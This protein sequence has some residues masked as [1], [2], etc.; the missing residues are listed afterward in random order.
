MWQ[1]V[2]VLEHL[3]AIHEGFTNCSDRFFAAGD[4]DLA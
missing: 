4:E 1:K 2:Y 3:F